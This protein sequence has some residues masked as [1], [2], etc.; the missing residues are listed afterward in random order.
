MAAWETVLSAL[1]LFLFAGLYLIGAFRR[2]RAKEP[3]LD[4]GF[5]P[6]LGY[7]LDFKKDGLG[8][9]QK[10]QKKHGDIFTL[11]IGGHFI[12]FVLDPHSYGTIV[13]ES[14]SK[15]DFAMFGSEVVSALFRF[16]PA[17]ED[18]KR[19]QALSVKYLMGEGL[20]VMNQAMVENLQTVMFHERGSRE[21]GGSWQQDGVYHYSCNTI[22][23]A[24]FLSF[25]GRESDD[26][27][28]KEVS[29][30]DDEI[31]QFEKL[32]EELQ[33]FDLLVP[34]LAYKTLT[35]GK[36]KEVQQLYNL[37]WDSLSVSKVHKRHNVSSWISE[38]ERMWAE[39]GMPENIRAR[40]LFLFLWAVQTNTGP[41]SFWVLVHL[42]KYPEAME[43]ARKEVDGLLRENGPHVELGDPLFDLTRKM[44]TKSPV[45]DSVI[46]ETLRL[47]VRS[48][49]MR[50]VVKDM[51]LQMDNGRKYA[52]RRG[53]R[54][55]L[56]PFVAAQ[57]DPEVYPE[58][59]TFRYDRFLNSEGL[60]KNFYKSG[61]KLK[62]HNMPFGIGPSKCPGRFFAVTE[63]KMF[64]FLML[65][66]FDLELVD[67]GEEI[68][69]ADKSQFGFGTTLPVHDIQFRYRLRCQLN[70]K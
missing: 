31:V 6:W 44:L 65:A 61:K 60:A 66:W 67:G 51:D 63:I 25:F 64:V 43:A 27:A 34:S 30:T 33:K 10:M 68:P 37:F 46:E 8:L 50:A 32:F 45:L 54:I 15:L 49:L 53:D 22:F 69:P 14:K 57:T 21:G 2:Q 16:N 52:L 28:E 42:L 47:K 59:M 3:P 26:K 4:K 1:L 48:I 12:T 11:L 18:H 70:T 17:G 58:P 9:L 39:K 56:S 38:Q 19:M 36:R 23:K 62:Y 13:K 5:L 20:A 24:S 41:A 55:A 35:P 7:A 40:H 29:L